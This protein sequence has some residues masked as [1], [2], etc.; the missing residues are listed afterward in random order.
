MEETRF[1]KLIYIV[2]RLQ[3]IQCFE[4]FFDFIETSN[5]NKIFSLKSCNE[6]LITKDMKDSKKFRTFIGCIE[7]YLNEH[8]KPPTEIAAKILNNMKKKFNVEYEKY[9]HSCGSSF[10]EYFSFDKNIRIIQN[11]ADISAIDKDDIAAKDN[12]ISKNSRNMDIIEE[13]NQNEINLEMNQI[14]YSSNISDQITMD[15]NKNDDIAMIETYCDAETKQL[16]EIKSFKSNEESAEF[17]NSNENSIDD[18]AADKNS[19][20]FSFNSSN[21]NNIIEIGD[22][23]DDIV[24]T[25]NVASVV[26]E[27]KEKIEKASGDEETVRI[28]KETHSNVGMLLDA[29]EIT[30][31]VDKFG[32]DDSTNEQIDQTKQANSTVP[33]TDTTIEGSNTDLSN[34][35]IVEYLSTKAGNVQDKDMELNEF[36]INQEKSQINTKILDDSIIDTNITNKDISQSNSDNSDDEESENS[37]Y[38]EKTDKKIKKKRNRKYSKSKP[39]KKR[40]TKNDIGD[41]TK[42]LNDSKITRPDDFVN[43][44]NSSKIVEDMKKDIFNKTISVTKINEEIVKEGLNCNIQRVLN[45]AIVSNSIIKNVDAWKDLIHNQV[46]DRFYNQYQNKIIK[47]NNLRDKTIVKNAEFDRNLMNLSSFG[48]SLLMTMM[49]MVNNN[50]IPPKSKGYIVIEEVLDVALLDSMLMFLGMAYKANG[51]K[52]ILDHTDADHANGPKRKQISISDVCAHDYPIFLKDIKTILKLL[53]PAHQVSDEHLLI[54]EE[55]LGVQTMHTD[56]QTGFNEIIHEDM[57]MSYS[58]IVAL[59]N[60]IYLRYAPKIDSPESDITLIKIPAYGMIIFCGNT[61]HSGAQW[62]ATSGEAGRIHFY[63]DP[64]NRLHGSTSQSF[65]TPKVL[66]TLHLFNGLF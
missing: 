30:E 15:N 12:E 56:D 48:K 39:K 35:D 28:N 11:N 49:E 65:I 45:A 58:A 46:M 2:L 13:N 63:I 22:Y 50:V 16:E 60:D 3:S 25:S 31:I 24:Q 53:F 32:A 14:I 43:L 41:D 10:Y 59:Q 55:G 52:N 4:F 57:M 5:R 33:P 21:N 9:D 20:I 66:A 7:K 61:I 17:M 34:S 27:V 62:I 37:K 8:T 18:K 6:V 26:E 29:S 38:E 54:S 42:P 1:T 36:T 40:N 23:E 47:K 19:D 64:S 51:W 44:W